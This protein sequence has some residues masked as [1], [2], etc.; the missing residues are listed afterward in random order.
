MRV[1]KIL[2]AYLVVLSLLAACGS[3]P[4]GNEATEPDNN[5][6][7]VEPVQ[8][9][10]LS[11]GNTW[12]KEEEVME[13]LNKKLQEDGVNIEVSLIRVPW[14]AWEQKSNLM[15][16]TG[17]EFELL[18]VMQDLKSLG[19]LQS[20]NAIVPLNDY[21][22]NYPELVDKFPQGM[23]DE[24]TV[25]GKILAVPAW[26][27]NKDG[28][29]HGEFYYRKD[30]MDKL[31]LSVPTTVDEV[32]DTSLKLQEAI[33]EEQG[34]K[35]Y[36]WNPMQRPPSWL[37]RTYD[38]Y[39]F[40][41]DT[42]LGIVMVTQ[43][44]EVHSWLESEEFKNDANVYK[45]MND[46]G[47][48]HPDL[49][50]LEKDAIDVGKFGT[51]A[52]GFES[53]DYASNLVAMQEGNPEA[54]MGDGILNPEKGKFRYFYSWN[55][56]AI[57]VTSKNPEAGL[58]FLNWLYSSKENHD[59][60]HYGIEGVTY[61]ASGPDRFEP[62]KG[63]DGN[64][65]YQFDNWMTPYIEYRRIEENIPDKVFEIFKEPITDLVTDSPV[66]GFRFNDAAV[67]QEAANLSTE[68]KRLMFPIKYGFVSYEEAFPDAIKR[69]K[70]V[71][72]DKYLEEYEKQFKEFLEK[73]K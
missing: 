8:M 17:E 43:D 61:N 18:H 72:L 2:C 42:N 70:A 33:F 31:G 24:V 64:N 66:V 49:L 69:L 34:K 50:A 59:L 19:Q 45:Q 44:G 4:G 10:F 56:N 53:Y 71:G 36:V 37:H 39:P 27:T 30:L 54:E 40:Y 51:F 65:L 58:Q 26:T 21:L 57:P 3:Q 60:F 32:I 46:L 13:A 25:D 9:R 7:S 12:A 47:L 62:I 38:R 48:I 55:A 29:S 11:P 23:W 41:V 5:S 16:S 67:A 35:A 68:V 1:W 22:E 15:L 20:N 63:T 28:K 14:N 73:Q 52:M 6:A